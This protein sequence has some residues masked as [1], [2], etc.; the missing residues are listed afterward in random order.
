MNISNII[1]LID[2]TSL[3]DNDN[4][5]S[6]IN[7]CHQAKTD[8]GNVASICLYPQFI[9]LAKKTI[10]NIDPSI[11]IATVIN[12]PHGNTDIKSVTEE[13]E[14]AISNNAD[15]IDMVMPYHAFI[16]GNITICKNMIKEVRNI[17]KDK[18]LKII[19]ETGELRS[20]TLIKNASYICLENKV[21]FIKTSTGKTPIGA[22]LDAT[23]IILNTIKE[24]QIKCGIKVSG[25]I[26]AIADAIAYIHLASNIMG[27][28]WINQKNFRI[29]ASSLLNNLL[30][31]ME[32]YQKP[33]K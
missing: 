8:Y 32:Y 25:G 7:L 29:G 13:A 6:T 18:I 3:N 19:I 2:L 17:C 10:A 23:Q 1:K 9:N 26:R 4:N 5:D 14:F 24:S 28:N 27:T 20:P 11:K 21:D 16:T 33:D 12:F 22:T 30:S 15:E 31:E